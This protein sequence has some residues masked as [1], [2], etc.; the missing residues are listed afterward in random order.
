MF[1]PDMG[2]LLTQTFWP[3]LIGLVDRLNSFVQSDA[4]TS[5]PP[6]IIRHVSFISTDSAT[7]EKTSSV[8]SFRQNGME[9]RNKANII[10]L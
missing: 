8:Q 10:M 5:L 6:E 9:I 4:L 2:D 7:A 3:G 1:L